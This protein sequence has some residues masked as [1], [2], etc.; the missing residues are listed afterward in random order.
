MGR[1]VYLAMGRMHLSGPLEGRSAG[2]CFGRSMW[3]ELGLGDAPVG[4]VSYL[5]MWTELGRSSGL[6]WVDAITRLQLPDC[7]A[8][9]GVS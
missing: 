7:M 8:R 1:F 5:S 2:V 6:S 4:H 9:F 3:I